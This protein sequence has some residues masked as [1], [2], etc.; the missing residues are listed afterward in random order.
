MALRVRLLL[1]QDLMATPTKG[2][3]LDRGNIL[4]TPVL[5]LHTRLLQGHIPHPVI[6]AL[7]STLPEQDM[8]R[9]PAR[10]NM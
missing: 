3:Q 9:H 2:H 7:G 4:A 5:I 6:Q 10:L 1:H 8:H